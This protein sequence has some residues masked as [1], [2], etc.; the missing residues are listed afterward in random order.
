[1]T[2]AAT[3][4]IASASEPESWAR[5]VF[6]AA[7]CV[8]LICGLRLPAGHVPAFT[9]FAVIAFTFSFRS[10]CRSFVTKHLLVPPLLVFVAIHLTSAFRVSNSNGVIFIF[11]TLV[12]AAFTAAFVNR[13]AQLPMARFLRLSG[14]GMFALL[15]FVV[16]YHLAH[17]RY[18]SWKLLSDAK[19]VFDVLPLM[20]LV[21]RRSRDPWA[22]FLFPL[23]LPAFVALILLSGERKAYILLVLL[24][25]LL[26]NLRSLNTYVL[27]LIL[28]IVVSAALSVDKGGYV[29]RQI[30]TLTELAQGRTEKTISDDARSW[31]IQH[32]AKL[33]AENP[34]IGVGTNGYG[35]TVDPQLHTNSAPHNE[36]VR[37]AADNG[38]SGLL[39][40]GATVLWGFIGIFRKRVG[41]RVRTGDEKRIA[42]AWFATVVVYLSFEALDF[43]VMTSFMFTP[44]V[45]FLRLDPNG[46]TSTARAPV[47]ATETRQLQFAQ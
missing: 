10:L 30:K 16:G 44:L 6:F 3:P 36:W 19:A 29:Q 1:M 2:A 25:P 7:A 45:Q 17:H 9:V 8:S 46:L 12:I 41:A 22:K 13:Y 40:Y 35:K 11:Q 5:D 18:T 4:S 37:V 23:L 32:A 26:L 28:V 47:A 27:P 24:A 31:A 43:I 42:Y 20:L 14:I 38:V 34:L 39:F 21:L 15:I 33:F